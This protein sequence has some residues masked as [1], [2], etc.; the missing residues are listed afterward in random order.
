M[1]YLQNTHLI[2]IAGW[3][4]LHSLWQGAV[5]AFALF[6]A[7]R[8]MKG[9]TA[10]ARYLTACLAM[11]LF[12]GLTATTFI[13]LATDK[14]AA[15]KISNL[16]SDK[17]AKFFG[18]EIA[19]QQPTINFREINDSI[20]GTGQK[21]ENAAALLDFDLAQF[22]KRAA[23]ILPFLVWLWFFGVILQ[24]LRLSGEFRRL[25]RLQ[26][27]RGEAS[28]RGRWR[29]RFDQLCDELKIKRTVKFIESA[30]TD[31][32]FTIGWLKPVVIVPAS[33]FLHLA[34]YELEAILRH[35][36]AHVRRHDYLVNLA[37][38]LIE[39]VLFYHPATWWISR[40]IRREREFACDDA[41]VR[42]SEDKFV[43]ARALANLEQNRLVAREKIVWLKLAAGGEN[44]HHR[45]KRIVES[46][47]NRRSSRFSATAAGLL[48]L[49]IAAFLINVSSA[50]FQS[51]ADTDD[52]TH[53][54]K[55]AVGFVSIP[56][57]D[58]SGDS[59]ETARILIEKLKAHR[60]PAIGFVAGAGI[61][62][63]DKLYPARADVVRQWR[64]AGFEI[65]IGNFK[66]VWFYDTPFDEYVAGVEKNASVTKQI[67]GEKD[68]PLRYF[69]YPYLNTGKTEED[70]NRFESWL[71]TRGLRS[72]KY[73]FD[74]QEWMYSFAYD[75]ARKDNDTEK[76]KLIQ[77]E[78]LDYMAEM[79]KH[80]EGYSQ[81]M[82]GRDINQTLVL[83]TS[84]LV[85]D[86][87]NEF[88]GM[89]ERNG[90][91]WVSMDEAQADAAYATRKAHV[92]T[93]SGVSWFERW[94][95]AR[96]KKL[97]DEPQVGKEVWK[98]WKAS[99]TGKQRF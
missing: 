88:F 48:L 4:L 46:N 3:T 62:N 99:Q 8:A 73:T 34:P 80:F 67:L 20:G 79:L 91:E 63:G 31:G 55:I 7:L 76:M 23:S 81:E 39:T 59:S 52:R 60:V 2:E 47:E 53:H 22:E 25:R 40:T 84:R 35:E 93:Q 87:A 43:Y 68:L 27:L 10:N 5:V 98:V 56:P 70:K 97:L 71:A 28:V 13:R 17:K 50:S 54:K 12:A 19:G 18:N 82:F 36:L 41:V 29:V 72:V 37:Q 33:A 51:S 78:F 77:A 57:V 66:H 30:T 94:Q 38:S 64:D 90:Y 15:N 14:T 74:N 32:A 75:Q 69:S 85:A 6:V 45:I 24:T 9:A 61:S 42:L 11:C 96:G 86:T 65:G 83:T 92:N 1:I 89:F 26:L 95:M 58:R 44:L 49:I 16:M 21:S